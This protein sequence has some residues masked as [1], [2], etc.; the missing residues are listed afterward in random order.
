MSKNSDGIGFLIGLVAGT[1][2]GVSIGMI[3]A[4]HSGEENRR[5]INDRTSEYKDRMAELFAEYRAKAAGVA[6]EIQSNTSEALR[7]GKECCGEVFSRYEEAMKSQE[8]AAAEEPAV[9]AAV[10]PAV[11]EA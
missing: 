1:A 2:I 8:P 5:I 7:R 9:I 11:E 6:S 4:P 3:L 10:Q